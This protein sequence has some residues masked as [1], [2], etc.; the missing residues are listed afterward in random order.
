MSALLADFPR[1]GEIW[2]AELP[3]DPPGKRRPAIIVS[4]DMRNAHP[5]A[6]SV[7]IIP[8][9]TS[10]HK[11]GPTELLLRSGETGLREDSVAW[12]GN[13]SAVSRANLIEPVAG[14]RPVTHSQ[15]CHLASLA[16]L[17]MGGV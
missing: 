11:C 8:L 6:L 4:P 13:I 7:L 5:R 17:A 14:H 12:T 2:W 16:R 15:I 10:V 9:S 1:R 3:F